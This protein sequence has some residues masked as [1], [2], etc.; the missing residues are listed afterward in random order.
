MLCHNHHKHP[1][2]NSI[3]LVLVTFKKA[4]VMEGILY[5]LGFA[6]VDFCH[7]LGESNMAKQ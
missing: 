5:V 2:G 4:P 1:G 6:C 7:L 3:C